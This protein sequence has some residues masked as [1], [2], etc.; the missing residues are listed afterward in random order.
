MS[1]CEE[2]ALT[3]PRPDTIVS[4]ERKFEAPVERVW[5][6]WTVP[7]LVMSWW[8]PKGFTTPFCRI[9]LRIGGSYLICMRSP[10]GRDFWTTGFYREIAP[11]ERLVSTDSF[12]DEKGN[13]VPAT[14]Y[15][16]SPK[17]P[18]EMLLT[19]TFAEKDGKTELALRHDGLPP[20][21]DLR[22]AGEGWNQSLDKLAAFLNERKAA[23]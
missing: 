14:A 12:A 18:L 23:L 9:S 4:I 13:V 17:I 16:M 7:D 3:E 11:L 2:E 1:P 5:M 15:G 6:A 10:E 8:G 21:N 22:D 19:V 20:G